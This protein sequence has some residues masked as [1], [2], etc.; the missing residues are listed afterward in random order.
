MPTFT[1]VQRFFRMLEPNK[2]AIT[3]LYIFAII[4]G[5]IALSLPLGI[6]AIINL[7]QGGE[8]SASWVLLVSIVLIGYMFNG[9]LQIIQLRITEDLQKDIFTRSAFEFTYRI[10]RIRMNA[11]QN[12]YAPELMNR[13]FDTITIQKGVAKILTEMTASGLSIFFGLILLSFYHSFFIIFSL[14]IFFLGFIIGKYIFQ[15]GLKSSIIESKYKYKVAF[16]LEEIA[17]TNTTFRLSCDSSLP[18]RKTD[19]LVD[20]YLVA[21][22]SHF[23]VLLRQYYLHII[24][25]LL[26]AAGFLILGGSLV[27]NQQMNIGQFVAAEIIVLLLISSSEKLLLTMETA[28]DLLTSLEK[29]GQVTDLEL[30][31]SDQNGWKMEDNTEGLNISIHNLFFKY[32]D[33]TEYTISGLNLDIKSNEKVCLT[34]SNGS[35]KATLLKLM[36]AFYE[37]DIGNIIYDQV[38]VKNHDMTALRKVIGECI[39]DD[40]IFEG[41]LMDN[42]TVGRD[43]NQKR[44]FEILDNIGLTSFINQLPLGYST[45]IG[46][47]G[48]RLPGSVLQKI[49]L[50]RNLLKEPRLL[51]V[52]DIFKNVE[53]TEK[54]KI[55]KYVLSKSIHRTVIIVSKD[56]DIMNLTDRIITLDEGNIL[57][58]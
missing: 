3:N 1:P 54:I 37:P 19:E 33:S 55:F 13:F 48:K 21:R 57:D 42:L 6:Q 52:E 46:P 41:T 39:T 7:I 58:N 2:K 47:Q 18:L 17:R 45:Q 24:F 12:H 14:L 16:W 53:K 36:S 51:I 49:I 50:A 8:I 27:F 44:M 23:K 30:E 22:E 9:A 26:I 34:G 56:P 32:P 20:A 28:Y 25:K 15:R 29:I 38:P 31:N 4:N 5:L 11:L 43:I 40:R 35:G 10:P